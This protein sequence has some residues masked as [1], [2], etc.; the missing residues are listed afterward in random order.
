MIAWSAAEVAAA[1]G[2]SLVSGAASSGPARAAIDT[3][4]LAPGVR[5]ALAAAPDASALVA[6]ASEG[7]PT[8][9]YL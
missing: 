4:A 2:A 1:A 7:P 6:N 9:V 5:V 8:A 3:R